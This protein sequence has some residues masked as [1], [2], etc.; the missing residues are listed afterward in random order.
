MYHGTNTKD[1]IKLLCQ[2]EENYNLLD[3]EISAVS[4]DEDSFCV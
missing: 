2:L 1:L 3:F 4:I